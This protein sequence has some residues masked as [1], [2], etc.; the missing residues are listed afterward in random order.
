MKT[1]QQ[2]KEPK[3]ELNKANAR[4]DRKFPYSQG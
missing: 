4:H 1:P 3:D 2:L